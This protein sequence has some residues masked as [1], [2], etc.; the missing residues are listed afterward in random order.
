MLFLAPP[1]LKTVENYFKTGFLELWN[2]LWNIYVV[3]TYLQQ[4]YSH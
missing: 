3:R 2:I 4:V 1:Y